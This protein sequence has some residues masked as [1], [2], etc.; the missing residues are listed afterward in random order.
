ML[1]LTKCANIKTWRIGSKSK[2]DWNDKKKTIFFESLGFASS[3][4]NILNFSKIAYRIIEE[5]KHKF[6]HEDRKKKDVKYYQV[7]TNV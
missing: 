4:I 2:Q 5:F 3:Y 6:T 1:K 7:F